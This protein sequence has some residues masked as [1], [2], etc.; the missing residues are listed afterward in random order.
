MNFVADRGMMTGSFHYVGRIQD[1][2]RGCVPGFLFPDTHP[3]MEP[4]EL[5]GP[6]SAPYRPLI[7]SLAARLAAGIASRERRRRRRQAA[8]Q[9]IVAVMDNQVDSAVLRYR[10]DDVA[11]AELAL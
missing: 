10:L 6:L 4:D 9:I 5:I 11:R 3:P 7:G 1:R 2:R 8:Q